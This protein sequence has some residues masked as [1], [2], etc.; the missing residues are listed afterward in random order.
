MSVIRVRRSLEK[1]QSTAQQKAA[2]RLERANVLRTGLSKRSLLCLAGARRVAGLGLWSTPAERY[3]H[4]TAGADGPSGAWLSPTEPKSLGRAL[5]V[6]LSVGYYWDRLK[7]RYLAPRGRGEETVLLLRWRPPRPLPVLDDLIGLGYRPRE[8]R[9]YLSGRPAQWGS[10][11][12]GRSLR[13][14]A[15]TQC[16]AREAVRPARRWWRSTGRWCR[17]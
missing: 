17:E 2:Y 13:S 4:S 15:R 8:S 12:V 3:I 5:A 6:K 7:A 14:S 9:I 1:D 11:V 16:S 10:P